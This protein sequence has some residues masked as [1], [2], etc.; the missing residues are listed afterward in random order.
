MK[1]QLS[2]AMTTDSMMD[3]TY[4]TAPAQPGRLV[5]SVEVALI[6]ILLMVSVLVRLFGLGQVPAAETE[7][8][9]ALAAWRSVWPD[10]SGPFA[11]PD[12]P[13]LFWAQ[14]TA[15]TL[16]GP[17]ELAMRVLTAF[18]GAMLS[19]SPLLFRDLIGRQQALAASLLLVFSPVLLGASR[20]SSPAVWAMLFAVIGLWAVFRY[21]QSQ[22]RAFAFT[23]MIAFSSLLLLAEPGG[24]VL[25]VVL[26]IAA[27]GSVIIVVGR[28][29]EDAELPGDAVVDDILARFAGWPW[30]A[31][32]VI[33]GIVVL[34]ISTGFLLFP[35]GF[36][37]VGEA[38]AGFAAGITQGQPGAPVG[39]P[40]LVAVFYEPFLLFLALLGL[41]TL[42]VNRRA[43]FVT[44]FL[45]LWL[46]AG[47]GAAYAYAGA[48]ADHALWLV[49]P[50][51]VLGAEVVVAAVRR[52]HINAIWYG[53]KA[54]D[55]DDV[56][57]SAERWRW[58]LA[59]L[60]AGLLV[61]GAV[62]LQIAA[63]GFFVA[64]DGDL[65]KFLGS[66]GFWE[67]S[68]DTGFVSFMSSTNRS[69]FNNAVI[70]LVPFLFALLF[71][72]VGYFLASSFWG[73]LMPAQSALIG[74]TMFMLFSNIGAGWSL[75]TVRSDDATEPWHITATSTQTR[76]LEQTLE[77]LK[78]RETQNMPTLSVAALVDPHGLTA[79][80]LRN[81]ENVTYASSVDDVI[82]QPIILMPRS[83]LVM[84]SDPNGEIEPDLGAA[85]LGQEFEILTTWRSEWLEGWQFL[86]WWV[87]RLE[88]VP[89][90]RFFDGVRTD[91][92]PP[93]QPLQSVVLWV[94]Q[95]VYNGNPFVPL[96]AP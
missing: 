43:T 65:L 90:I 37:L 28:A 48:E 19:L 63:R 53:I 86:P 54:E 21:W 91:Y 94:R 38:L 62:H 67:D 73:N 11:L 23:A 72:L 44:W 1:M 56:E 36:G 55:V 96:E 18:A 40:A 95:D 2:D 85:Y 47:F 80:L 13:V 27:V 51:A 45:T 79:W 17:S 77:E 89:E 59:L 24:V 30:A 64:Q 60:T 22:D 61:I 83:M 41:L 84:P 50:A 29:P 12:S 35:P 8:A 76:L 16:I 70:S 7:T 32:L 81:L 15:F 39:H 93:P 74:L 87:E 92:I 82:G 6:V 4:T 78:F 33:S 71:I 46:I 25:A 3:K 69:Y 88:N 68:T 9:S 14:K 42:L 58:I 34:A 75:V 57:R 49:V 5:I 31:G 52:V 66:V 10:A 20:F 26:G